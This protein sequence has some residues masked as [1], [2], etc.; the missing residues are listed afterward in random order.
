MGIAT[1]AAALS[2]G[3]GIFNTVKGIKESADAKKAIKNAPETPVINP[4]EG[5]RVN[6]RG[7]EDALDAGRGNFATALNAL[8]RRGSRGV[9]GGVPRLTESN[10]LL[11]EK[12]AEVIGDMDT[13]ASRIV[14]AGEAERQRLIQKNESDNLL[15][16]G[17]SLQ[18][19][20]QNTATS[21]RDIFGGLLAIDSATNPDK[22]G[23]ERAAE[24]PATIIQVP[25]QA[26]STT[27]SAADV[28]PESNVASSLVNESENLN[29]LDGL[30]G[31]QGKAL[32]ENP[33]L[34]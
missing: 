12:I 1:A 7:A 28:V 30:F 5:V 13:E 29:P 10:I 27:Q 3:T 33:L 17:Q 9:V 22:G 14:A 20:N 19:A 18:V 11:N 4:N 8:E 24:D 15:G 31:S 16:L 6:T 32:L 21:I 2:L 26:V 23:G 34:N 25:G